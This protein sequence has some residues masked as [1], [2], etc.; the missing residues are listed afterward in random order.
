MIFKLYEKFSY[1]HCN[2]GVSKLDTSEIVITLANQELL[3]NPFKLTSNQT[4]I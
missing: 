3:I 1:K 4:D 2:A